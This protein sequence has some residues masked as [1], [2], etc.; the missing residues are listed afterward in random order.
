MPI[1]AKRLRAA[2]AAGAV[3]ATTARSGSADKEHRERAAFDLERRQAAKTILTPNEVSGEYDAGRLLVTSRRGDVRPITMT[4]IR[5]FQTNIRNLKKKFIGGITPQSVID[6]SMPADIQRSNDQIRTAVLSS[7]RGNKYHFLTNA[8]PNSKVSRHHVNVEFLDFDSAA[9]AS[10]AD[11]KKMGKQ[12]A[13]GRLK[14][15]CDCEHFTFVLRYVA[16][17]GKYVEGRLENGYPKLT[18]PKLDG[19]ACKHALRVMHVLLKDQTVHQ[20]I[21]GQVT[22]AREVLDARKL[23]TEHVKVAEQREHAA[24]QAGA[25]KNST[26]LRTSA[27][28]AAVAAVRKA[29]TSMKS[30]AVEHAA[31]APKGN[32]RKIQKSAQNL[33]SLGAITQDQYNTIVSGAK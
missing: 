31:A 30:D 29:R 20:K 1:D 18:N 10:S 6:L 4:D 8:G 27:Q 24:K 16:T 13:G 15:E 28:K 33:L 19:V 17:V 22:K 9:G 3:K 14:F 7:F 11:P 21:A 32:A 5:A 12:V 26:N 25:H 2:I 23:K